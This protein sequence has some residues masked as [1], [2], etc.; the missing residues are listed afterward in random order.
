MR[1]QGKSVHQA[2]MLWELIQNAQDKQ[3]ITI[4]RSGSPSVVLT[5]DIS[6]GESP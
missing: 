3:V 4:A 6:K 1:Q 2:L 5:I